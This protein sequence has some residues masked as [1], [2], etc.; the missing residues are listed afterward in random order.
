MTEPKKAIAPTSLF[1]R[2][3]RASLGVRILVFMALGVAAGVALGES[4]TAVRP[5]GDVFIRL[6]VMAAIPLVFFNLLAGLTGLSDVRTVGR[7]ARRILTYYLATTTV[8]LTIGLLV[9]H[10]LRPGSGMSLSE[11]VSDSI[12]QVPSVVEVLL[13]LIPANVFLAFAEGNVSQI[14]VFAILL[15]AA[16]LSLAETRRAPL[17]DAFVA[18]ADA[19]RQLVDVIMRFGPIGIGALTAA[20]VGEYGPQLL[21]PLAIFLS[22]IWG[23]QIVMVGLYLALLVLF[24]GMR[25]G[26]FLARTGP[27]WATTAG[28][29]SSLASLAYA[30]EIADERLRL[31]KRVYTFTLPLGAQLNKDGTS[32]MLASVL[33]FTA[34]AAGVEFGLGSQITILLVGLILSEGSGGIP[35]GGLVIAL[36]F[37]QAFELPLEIAAI[38]G[39]IYRLIDMGSTTI[40][41]MGDMVGTAIVSRLEGAWT[42]TDADGR[43]R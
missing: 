14:V 5:V 9:M 11:P 25:P 3:R 19:L 20:T 12:G 43:R 32:I 39:G 24:T 16:T 41:V 37:V 34:Q 21:G 15:G 22:A 7:M 13:D 8:A 4:A 2:Y 38:V 31:P 33:L 40:N 36:I 27:L 1:A 42:P 30:F 6:L 29:C 28:T 26:R 23:A 17:R 18:M 35:G 10:A